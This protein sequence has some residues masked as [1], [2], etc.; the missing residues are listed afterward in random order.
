VGYDWFES[1]LVL[2]L[3]GLATRVRLVSSVWLGYRGETYEL[4]LIL[5][6]G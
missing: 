5:A 2:G 1:G 3:V 4:C 6:T